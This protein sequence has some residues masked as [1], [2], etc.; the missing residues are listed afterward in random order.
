MISSPSFQ[1][2]SACKVDLSCI[3]VNYNSSKQLQNCLES[4]YKTIHG[5]DFE[6]IVVDN[7][8]DD[9]GWQGLR[10]AFPQAKFISNTSNVGFS[11]ANN[12]AAKLAQG[13]ALIFINPDTILSDQA[14]N[15]MQSYIL[16][17]S[18][19]GALGP[20]VVDPDGSLQYSCRRFPTIWTGLFNRYSILTRLFPKNRFTSQYLMLD[21][22]HNEILPVDW[23]SGCCLM[24]PKKVFEEIGG[25]D[26][27]YFLFNEDID[28]GRMINETGK[29][30]IYFPQAIV[31]H[32]VSTSNSKTSARVIVKRH[33]GMMHYFK[34]H[35]RVNFLFRGTINFFILM[36]G[37]T[38]LIINLVK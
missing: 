22:D 24:V 3:I 19:V 28:L 31:N 6:V 21:F 23:L 10:E 12:Q 5:I 32:Q 27:N 1:Q 13:E 18:E 14:I 11:K 38:Q 30:V 35:H 4:I 36:R 7:S 29:K 15:S 17:N 9:P 37:I 20:K 25:F 26:E 8:E 16:S 33:L 2:Q 34:K